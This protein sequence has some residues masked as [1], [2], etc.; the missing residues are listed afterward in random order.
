[1]P[2][3]DPHP[4]EPPPRKPLGPLTVLSILLFIA[5]LTQKAFHTKN[6]SEDA[7]GAALLLTGWMGVVD[8]H[9]SWLANPALFVSWGQGKRR[10]PLLA[11]GTALV[12]LLFAA[13]F[14][15]RKTIAMNEGGH[16]EAITGYG[17]G[18]WL[19]IAS[20][21]AAIASHIWAI[22][23]DRLAKGTQPQT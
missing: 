4:N 16:G 12:A 22:R 11:L 15:F 3:E 7:Y 5:S 19:W 23:S 17:P 8:G 20:I 13:S 9:Y 6:G 18:Y 21:T 1:M 14:L 2:A 10:E